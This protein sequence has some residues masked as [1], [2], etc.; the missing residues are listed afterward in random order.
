MMTFFLK[1]LANSLIIVGAACL[2][3]QGYADNKPKSNFKLGVGVANYWE[4]YTQK[5]GDDDLGL[6]IF[7]E[8]EN[9]RF[10][11]ERDS[12]Y[13]NFIENDTFRF[14]ILGETN[15][16]GF[17]DDDRK[18]F[19]GMEDR[20]H[21]LDAGFGLGFT[22][23]G[24]ELFASAAKDIAD[25]HKGEVYK[26]KYHYLIEGQRWNF[27]PEIEVA[28]LSDDFVDY[29]YGVR[30]NEV[31]SSRSA[32]MGD[33]ATRTRVGV[34]IR[35]QMTPRFELVGDIGLESIP[36]EIKNSPL[37]D[38]DSVSPQFFIGLSYQF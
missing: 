17:E 7:M 1:P 22:A 27:K 38:N 11:L 10:H 2:A 19:N 15:G 31:T 28:R 21:S 32:Y 33:A 25:S 16:I 20:D 24:G 9:G 30:N 4:E 8:Y 5:S 34:D 36:D 6:E 23:L 12:I 35:Y 14:S 18:V 37:T 3:A 29:Y 26:L 13:Y